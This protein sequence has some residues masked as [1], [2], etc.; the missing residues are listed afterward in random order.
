MCLGDVL[1]VAN[2]CDHV[3]VVLAVIC[4]WICKYGTAR[5]KLDIC[6]RVLV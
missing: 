4:D 3:D 1:L 5:F 6:M 2:T